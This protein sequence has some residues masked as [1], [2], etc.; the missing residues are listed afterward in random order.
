MGSLEWVSSS[1]ECLQYREAH[2]LQQQCSLWLD[3]S[4]STCF[5]LISHSVLEVTHFFLSPL[6]YLLF[7]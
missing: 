6:P 5:H 7:P 2:Y 4:P 3:I 1:D